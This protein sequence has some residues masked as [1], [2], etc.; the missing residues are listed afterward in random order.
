MTKM[1]KTL[2][3]SVVAVMIGAAP[4]AT[5]AAAGGSLSITYAPRDARHAQALETGLLIYGA[6]NQIKNGGIKQKGKNNMAGLGQNGS[7]NFGV[8]HQEGNGHHG[9]LQQNGNGNA[10]GLFQFGKHT[11]AD[12]V[13][14]GNGKVGTTFQFGW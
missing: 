12:V 3:A 1:T 11:N 10:Y 6:V 13:Q 8:V 2:I 5:P 14:N 7:G 4:L 9:T